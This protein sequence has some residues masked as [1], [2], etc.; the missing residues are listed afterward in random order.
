MSTICSVFGFMLC[1]L[2]GVLIGGR[3]WKTYDLWLVLSIVA[4]FAGV[5]AGEYFAYTHP[6]KKEGIR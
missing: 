6:L 4:S 3:G 2:L 5:T 1:F